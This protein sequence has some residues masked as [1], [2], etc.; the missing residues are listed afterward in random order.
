[1]ASTD[2]FGRAPLQIGGALAAEMITVT[3][4]S[5]TAADNKQ[6]DGLLIQNVKVGYKQPISK[7]FGLEG[8]KVWYVVGRPS[9]SL[10]ATHIVADGK[11]MKNLYVEYGNV[12]KL[13]S[14]G[15]NTWILGVAKYDACDASGTTPAGSSGSAAKITLSNIIIHTMNLDMSVNQ[16]N[17]IMTD[18]FEA[19][20]LK[21][22]LE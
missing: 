18:S 7:L 6:N 15:K 5:A 8:R 20:F 14:A 19:E 10:G 9:G 1:M 21:L 13:A 4:G 12:C 2:V 16:G 17:Y 3:F 11:L 22:Q